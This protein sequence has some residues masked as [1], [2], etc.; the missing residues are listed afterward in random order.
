MIDFQATVKICKFIALQPS[1]LD[2]YK[3]IWFD[4]D[5]RINI[6]V[7]NNICKVVVVQNTM[8][9]FDPITLFDV[10]AQINV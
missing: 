2:F 5:A 3:K 4:V 10:V 9:D 8:L 1:M 7:Q 6:L